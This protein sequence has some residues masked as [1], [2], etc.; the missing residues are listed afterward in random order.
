MKPKKR[1]HNHIEYRK[2]VSKPGRSLRSLIEKNNFRSPS[3]D[4]ADTSQVR[5]GG[6]KC[7]HVKG[8]ALKS[9]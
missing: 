2:G 5:R 9:L 1:I 3:A 7:K 8:R 4:P 6:H